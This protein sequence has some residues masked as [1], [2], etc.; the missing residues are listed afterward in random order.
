MLIEKYNSN[1]N[2]FTGPWLLYE[3]L[4]GGFGIPFSTLGKKLDYTVG[5]TENKMNENNW[6][7]L[8]TGILKIDSS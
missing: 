7:A 1:K 5:V 2:V 4:I 6:E 3:K 8:G